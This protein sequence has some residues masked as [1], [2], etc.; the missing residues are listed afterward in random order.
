MVSRIVLALQYLLVLFHVRTYKNSKLPLG[1]IAGF[2]LAA[3]FIYLGVSLYALLQS[4]I[5][6]RPS[7]N[8]VH[9][10]STETDHAYR[11]LYVVAVAEMVV[12]IGVASQWRVV[13]FKGTH[14]IERMSLL[15]LY[16]REGPSSSN[17]IKFC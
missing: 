9:S 6:L 4:I 11:A 2:S 12:N 17:T 7:T 16:I 3:A 1:L 15:T 10:A 5:L 14:L 13:S 8:T